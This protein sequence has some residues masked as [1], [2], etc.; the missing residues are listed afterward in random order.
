MMD[1]QM[2]GMDGLE[3][4]R[5]IR[6]DERSHGIP[7]IALMYRKCLVTVSAVWRPAPTTI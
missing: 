5:R 2:P 6:A 4:S 3:A 7:I 1:I